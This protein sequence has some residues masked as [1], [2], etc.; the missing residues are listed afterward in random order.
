[1]RLQLGCGYDVKSGWINHDSVQLP[2]VDVTHDLNIRPWPWAGNSIDEIWIKDVLEHLPDTIDVMEEIYRITK[3]GASIYI[4]VPYWNSW[5]AITDPTHVRQ[6][7]EF[8]FNFFD[9]TK[10]EC[11]ERP[12][13]SG[14]RFVIERLGFGVQLT[15]YL[16]T[17][18]RLFWKFPGGIFPWKYTVFFHP[19]PK[20]I[21]GFLASYFSNIIIGLEVYLRRDA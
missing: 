13:Y 4:A 16:H 6:F 3:P 7:N 9:P 20:W 1:M 17:E 15:P 21:L 19:F 2:G 11:R 10:D 18:T 14:A 5:E 12:Y 8:T